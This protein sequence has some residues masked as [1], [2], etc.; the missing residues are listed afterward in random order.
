MNPTKEN[1]VCQ[2]C[3]QIIGFKHILNN[4]E[5]PQYTQYEGNT[6]LSTNEFG[7]IIRSKINGNVRIESFGDCERYV[8]YRLETQF[9]CLKCDKKT[10]I[11]IRDEY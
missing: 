8:G 2:H 1:I 3:N 10:T 5:H 9:K 4:I 6:I 11:S 7:V